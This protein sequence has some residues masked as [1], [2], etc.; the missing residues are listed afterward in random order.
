MP[1]VKVSVNNPINVTLAFSTTCVMCYEIGEEHSSVMYY[2][3][4]S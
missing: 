3:Y 1:C 4:R 2:G